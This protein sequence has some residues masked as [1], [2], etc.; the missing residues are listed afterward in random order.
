MVRILGRHLAARSTIAVLGFLA[1][2]APVRAEVE[3]TSLALPAVAF[4]FST[5]YI[6]QD[7]GIFKSEGLDVTERVITG[8]GSANAVISGSVDFS[9]SSGVTLTRAAARHQPL[10]AIA[11]TFDRT[12]FWIVLRKSIAEQRHFDPNAPLAER[13]KVLKGLRFGVGAIQAIP[14]AYLKLIARI[15]GLDPERDLVVA[16]V[17]PPDQVGAM[18]RGAIDGV[19]S[20]PPVVEQLLHDGIGVVVAD[21]T[22]GKVDPPS[23]AHIAANVVMTRRK[24]CVDHRSICVKMGHAMVKANAFM[25]EHP[26]EA[27]AMLGKR[28]HV[29]DP[30]VLAAA[31]RHTLDATPSPPVLDAKELEAADEMNVEAGFMKASDKLPSYAAIFT[32]EFLK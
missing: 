19:S 26:K 31:Y 18:Q 23:L 2:A 13:A 16:G 24:F 17:V 10:I 28:F 6:A 20:G 30:A 22:T 15:G 12:G 8:I 21:G 7:A 3:H 4:I 32:N 1:L 27:M 9:M 5:A 11:N 25:H 29:K 14:H